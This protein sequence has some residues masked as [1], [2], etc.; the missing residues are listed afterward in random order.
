MSR[1]WRVRASFVD[2]LENER[3]A[4]AEA[5]LVEAALHAEDE[6]SRIVFENSEEDI[7]EVGWWKN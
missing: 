1:R 2:V 3:T 5:V 4:G 6:V 7:L